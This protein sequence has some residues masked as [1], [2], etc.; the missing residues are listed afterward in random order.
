M[1]AFIITFQRVIKSIS[2]TGIGNM[3][4]HIMYLTLVNSSVWFNYPSA[5][6]LV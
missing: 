1:A 6:L 5:M 2:D 3:T 4:K